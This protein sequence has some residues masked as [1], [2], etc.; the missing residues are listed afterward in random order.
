M[1]FVLNSANTV[2]PYSGVRRAFA[3]SLDPYLKETRGELDRMLVA[4]A[5]GFGRDLA[6]VTSPITGKKSYSTGGGIFNAV[7]PIRVYDVEKD[8]VVQ[9]LTKI[10]YPINN[11]L[12]TGTDSVQLAPEHRE[13]LAQILAESGL[14][15]QLEKT[16][17]SPEWQAMAKAYAG[18]PVSAETIIGD[19]E[20]AD[21]HVKA[22]GKDCQ[23]I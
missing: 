17:K 2:L 12:K 9:Q 18:R 10:G 7:S 5:P 4:A 11:I 23:S 14:R 1:A 16:M 8:Y 3:N 21:P 15:N 20:T 22:I 13:R 19:E 6:T